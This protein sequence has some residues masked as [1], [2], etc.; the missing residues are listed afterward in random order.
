[1]ND[2]LGGRAALAAVH[3]TVGDGNYALRYERAQKR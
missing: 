3:A 2:D 1:M